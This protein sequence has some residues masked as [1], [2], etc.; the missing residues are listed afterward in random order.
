MT[1][2]LKIAT[3]GVALLATSLTMGGI[4]L[5]AT[6]HHSNAGQHEHYAAACSTLSGQW[7]SAVSTGHHAKLRQARYQERIGQRDCRSH[8]TAELKAGA[9]H[10]RSA[11]R[12]IG[13]RPSA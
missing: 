1:P 5:A 4:A 11:L 10:Y 9:Q 2:R 3:F 13:V 8:K 12:M 6:P 7:S